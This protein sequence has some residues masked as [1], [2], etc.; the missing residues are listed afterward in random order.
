MVALDMCWEIDSYAM[1][2]V[3]NAI[4]FTYNV[5]GKLVSILKRKASKAGQLLGSISNNRFKTVSDFET[6]NIQGRSCK[7]QKENRNGNDADY[8]IQTT[9][10]K[11]LI[12][13][14]AFHFQTQ[15]IQGRFFILIFKLKVSKAGLRYFKNILSEKNVKIPS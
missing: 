8:N 3:G 12:V 14:F 4:Q 2:C 11:H 13:I 1:R 10:F 6:Q 5:C 7:Q 15:N 9:H